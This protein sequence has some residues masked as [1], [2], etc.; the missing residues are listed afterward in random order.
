MSVDRSSPEQVIRRQRPW[1]IA[2]LCAWGGV[3]V[4]G[5][6]GSDEVVRSPEAAKVVW[7]GGEA[8]GEA[9]APEAVAEEAEPAPAAKKKAEA[10][11]KGSDAAEE[12]LALEAGA[13]DLDAPSPTPARAEPKAAAPKAAVVAAAAEDEAP[14][15]EPP[16]AEPDPSAP[17]PLAELQRR[18]N[19]KEKK[20]AKG[21]KAKTSESESAPEPATSA[22]KGAE[23]CRAASFSIARVRSACDNGG[24]PGAKRVMKEAIN[25]A[26]ATGKLLKCGDCH[27][28]MRDY[29]LKS[30]AVEKLERWL[31]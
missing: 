7:G 28:N 6:G 18:R 10:P 21:K 15:P 30:D 27:S 20:L 23:P 19:Q 13:I 12:E 2:L 9:P 17:P 29:A 24:R 14:T 1:A 4:A 26:T 25:K 11:A 31:E 8:N 5:C 3:A 16:A 22:Y